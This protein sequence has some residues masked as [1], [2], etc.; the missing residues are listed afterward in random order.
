MSEPQPEN[1]TEHLDRLHAVR[2]ELNRLEEFLCAGRHP[3]SGSVAK[4]EQAAHRVGVPAWLRVTKGENRWPVAALMVVAIGLQL[5]LPDR[6]TLVSR[7]LMPS[8]ELAL[9]LGLMVANPFRMDR[10]STLLRA[11]SLSLTSL[12]SVANAWS[13]GRL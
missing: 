2:I 1:E 9:L 4:A 3:V 12:L 6:L 5:A 11:A 8:L 7:W 13:A 10:E